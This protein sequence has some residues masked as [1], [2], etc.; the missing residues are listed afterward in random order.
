MTFNGI[1]VPYN[2][3]IFIIIL[4]SLF[5]KIKV[6]HTRAQRNFQTVQESIKQKTLYSFLPA[7]PRSYP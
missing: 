5:L 6:K 2:L 7:V 3:F 1:L 4:T